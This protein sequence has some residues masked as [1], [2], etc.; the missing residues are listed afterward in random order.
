[1]IKAILKG[2]KP[3]LKKDFERNMMNAQEEYECFTGNVL[4]NADIILKK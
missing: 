3:K 1:M 2:Q 4:G